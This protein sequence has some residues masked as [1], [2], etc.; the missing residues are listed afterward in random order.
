VATTTYVYPTRQTLEKIEQDLLPVLTTDADPIFGAFPIQSSMDDVLR[1]EQEDNY[2]GLQQIRGLNGEPSKIARVGAKGY[3]MEPGVY[4]EKAQID[5]RELT[6]RRQVGSFT[7]RVDVTDLVREIQEQMITREFARVRQVLWTLATAGTFSVSNKDGV[8]M[9][10][11][12]F[13]I[14][15][16]TASNAWSVL[17]SSTPL[18]DLRAVKLLARGH[19][20]A[21]NAAAR[22][23]ANQ[24]TVNNM[25]ANTNSADLAGR[26][27]SA[28]STFNS[29][30]NDNTI[31]TDNAL[32]Q[33][34]VMDDGYFDD[35][36]TFQL[37][38]P[39]GKVVVIGIRPNGRPVG[40]Y[41]MTYNVTN[42]GGGSYMFVD[43]S[44]GEDVPPQIVV[45]RGHNGGPVIWFP[46]AIVVM[47][48]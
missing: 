41:R 5:E 39:N 36:G 20:V 19:S 34:E 26:R 16:F 37:F 3:L 18:A 31:F 6:K 14:Q 43:D 29:L 47:N 21:F 15:T 44:R 30:T 48:V 27:G 28:G 42:N 45:Q 2:R 8:L 33:I 12:T 24:V 38:I 17:A 11:D 22:G 4:G 25:L 35:N 9:Q 32:P 40:A 23:Y 10:T 7:N 13:P 1:W 46:S